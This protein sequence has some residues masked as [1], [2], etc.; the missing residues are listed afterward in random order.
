MS[1]P[2]G[3]NIWA[4][5]IHRLNDKWYLYV[6]ADDGADANHRMFVLEGDSADPQGSY[7]LK[8]QISTPSNRWAIDGTGIQYG[9]KNYFIWSGRTSGTS[10]DIGS[11]PS[12]YIAE[13]SNPWTLTGAR[14]RISSP[15][16]AWETHGHPV[17]E[18]PEI[19]QHGSDVFLTYSA[20]A[21]ETPYYAIG[22]LKL[23]RTNPLLAGSW[24][25]LAQPLFD[26]GNGVEGTGHASF[27]NTPDAAQD[28][29]VYHARTAPDPPRDAAQNSPAAHAN[30][31]G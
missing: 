18:G 24:T 26:Q 2:Y 1:T 25:R 13:M 23:T 12:L 14:T 4:P 19:L 15:T 9:G 30:G 10:I 27:V 11:S 8:G 28:W 7:T 31:Y 6:A 20:S 21:F 29:I 5:E 17:N 16:F 22:A 3:N